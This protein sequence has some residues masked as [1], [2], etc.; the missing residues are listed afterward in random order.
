M[1]PTT[2][3]GVQRFPVSVRVFADP[4]NRKASTMID[5]RAIRAAA[6]MSQAALAEQMGMS[7]TGQRTVSQIEARDDWLL[8]SLAAYIRAAGGT[9]ELVVT[10]GDD[11]LR[12]T[13]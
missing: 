1:R 2:S 10:V 11:E 4:S 7:S 3:Q 12:F 5:L 9:A 8:S 6:G 13:I